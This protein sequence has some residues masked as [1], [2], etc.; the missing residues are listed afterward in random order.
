MDDCTWKPWT[1]ESRLENAGKVESF[2]QT[3]TAYQNLE[4]RVKRFK[5]ETRICPHYRDTC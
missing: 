1:Y 4:L 5:N 2:K 3:L